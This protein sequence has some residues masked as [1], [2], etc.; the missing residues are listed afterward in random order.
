M[1]YPITGSC[2]CGQVSFALKKAPIAVFA[3]HCKECQKLSTSP[4]SVTVII[5]SGDIEFIGKMKEWSR[6]AESGNKNV[7]KFCPECGN[8]IYHFTP[9]KPETVKLKLKPVGLENDEIFAPQAHV[10]VS[11]KLSWVEIP[12]GATTFPKQPY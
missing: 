9:D 6:I 1:T 12:I 2:Q 10:W 7:A 11:E 4:Y 5:N 8:R 3:C